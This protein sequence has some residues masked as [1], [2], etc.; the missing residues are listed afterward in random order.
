M[1][2]FVFN[3]V[4]ERGEW[5]DMNATKFE[6]TKMV[7]LVEIYPEGVTKWVPLGRLRNKGSVPQGRT[8]HRN[9]SL[10]GAGKIPKQNNKVTL[11][12]E[13]ELLP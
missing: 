13:F 11:N 1:N 10:V 12:W 9:I 2:W 4:Y 7:K 5:P 6:S 3:H 8:T